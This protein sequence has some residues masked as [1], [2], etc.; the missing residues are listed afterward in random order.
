VNVG[1]AIEE[2]YRAHIQF[3]ANYTVQVPGAASMSRDYGEY[4]VSY[5]LNKNVLEAVRHVALKVNE[6]PASRRSDYESFENATSGETRQ[7]LTASIA[8]ASAG[9]LAAAAKS[10]GTPEEMR[11]AGTSALQRRDFGGAIELLKRSLDQDPNQKDAWDDLGRAYAALG[12]HEDAIHAFRKQIEIDAFHKS[13]NQDLAAELQEM[14]KF[15]EAVAAYRKQLEIT[16]FNKTTHKSLGLLLAEQNQ[17]VEATKELEAADSMPPDDPEVKVALARVYT[18]SGDTAKAQALLKSVTGVSSST[19][20][21]DIYTSALRD[22]IDPNQT[23]REARKTLDDVGDQFDSGE[24]DR[25]TSSALRAMDLVALAWARIGW[26]KFKQGETLEA[27]QFLNSAWLLSQSG[28]VENRLARVL[29]KEGQ[30]EKVRHAL[31]LAV[32]AGGGEVAVSRE[33]LLKVSSG[34]GPADKEIADATAELVQM[35][36]IKV[37]ALPG[38]TAAAQFALTFDSSNKPERVEWLDGVASLRAAGDLLR[39]QEFP[40]KFPD[41]SSVKIVRKAK[42]SCGP[43]GCVVEFQPLEGLQSGQ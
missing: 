8:P 35:R 22:D 7:L 19:A 10:G 38:V 37:P 21:A 25:S 30:K 3:P 17:D 18:H 36:T 24:F 20:G 42:L 27:M 39:E 14:G 13:A 33:Q 26:A 32:A 29:E 4:A 11:K 6:L 1:P 16:P 40:V 5:D 23:V 9:A 34:A 2:T 31:A 12:E 41:V 28:T 15:E 43:S